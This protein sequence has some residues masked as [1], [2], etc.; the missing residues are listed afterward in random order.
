MVKVLL[1]K[2]GISASLDAVDFV[3]LEIMVHLVSGHIICLHRFYNCIIL[4]LLWLGNS[5]SYIEVLLGVKGLVVF[6]LT[7]DGLC[8]DKAIDGR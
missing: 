8:L 6:F 5:S 3:L 4:G 7:G 1:Q 2:L